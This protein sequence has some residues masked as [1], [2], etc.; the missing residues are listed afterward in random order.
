MTAD[1]IEKLGGIILQKERMLEGKGADRVLSN[2]SKSL[3]DYDVR[4]GVHL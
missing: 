3:I 1:R 2:N 4:T